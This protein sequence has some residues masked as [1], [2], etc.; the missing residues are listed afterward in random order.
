MKYMFEQENTSF[1]QGF[2]RNGQG[3]VTSAIPDLRILLTVF[4]GVIFSRTFF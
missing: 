3:R 2:V 4:E 1:L